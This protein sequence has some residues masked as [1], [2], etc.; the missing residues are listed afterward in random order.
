MSDDY[1]T[2]VAGHYAREGSLAERILTLVTA[3]RQGD[4]PLSFKEL[5]PADQ[6]HL[7]G[8]D[9]S[10]E[11]AALLDAKPGARILDVGS[12]IGGSARLLASAYQAEVLGIDL[13]AS[14]CADAA[15]LS[16]ATGLGD[17]T[18]FVCADATNIPLGDASAD[19]AWTQHVA[20]NIPDKGAVYKEVARVLKPGGRFAL[21]DIMLGPT[22]DPHYP[23][24]WAS[25][26]GASFLLPPPEVHA[27][28]LAAGLREHV[29]LDRTAEAL[30]WMRERQ[31]AMKASGPPP[32]SLQVI[33]G[34]HFGEMMGNVARNLE[35]GRIV[36]QLG[37]FR[38]PLD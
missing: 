8:K 7:R 33:L 18:D 30:G 9:A 29:W 17:R 20:M 2:S 12:G 15:A 4:G 19:L 22:G 3:Q 16:A 14:F 26:A 28:L 34:T 36:V 24:P 10:E 25:Q 37:M 32:L 38:K 6:F 31:A 11:M 27:L 5:A 23:T 1:L 13:T 21:Y 35:E